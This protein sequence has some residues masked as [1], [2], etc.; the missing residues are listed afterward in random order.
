MKSALRVIALLASLSGLAAPAQ[1]ADRALLGWGRLFTNDVLGDGYDRW[2]TGAYT[3]SIAYGPDWE[4]AAPDRFGQLLEFRLRSELI[5]PQSLTSPAADDRRFAGALTF[6]VHS[7]SKM[8]AA[9]FRAGVDL[10]LTGPQ[11]GLGELQN[12][13]HKTFGLEETTVLGDQ[14]PNNSY[15]TVSAELSREL[16][17][18]NARLRPFVELQHGVE[19]FARV[20]ADVT[21]GSYGQG[22]LMARDSTTGH[23]YQVIRSNAVSGFSFLLGGDFAKVFS[24]AYLP[25]EDGIELTDTRTRIRAGMNWQGEN[26]GLFYGLT[27]LSEE[28][29]TQPEGQLVGALQLRLFF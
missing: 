13:I 12:S 8:G 1:A 10:T 11:T 22:A 6:G 16:A 2:R 26:R 18:G 15:A 7:Y 24:S 23:R 17:F 19:S 20:G 3:L 27:Y 5:A 9:D 4:G 21:F 25:E 14:I 28:F 29:E